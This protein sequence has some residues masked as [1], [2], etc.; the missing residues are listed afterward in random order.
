MK[1]LRLTAALA[2]GLV[3]A[4]TSSSF[5]QVRVEVAVPLPTIRFTAPPPL[6]VIAPGVQVVPDYPEEVFFVQGYYWHRV[7]PRWYRARDYRGGWAVA[8]APVVPATIVRL[9]PGRYKKYVR[10]ERRDERREERREDHGHG[11]GHG[12]GHGKR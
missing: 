7:G 9:P 12:N 2:F 4:T 8:P 1:A 5:A 10:E 3:T 6:V 11:N